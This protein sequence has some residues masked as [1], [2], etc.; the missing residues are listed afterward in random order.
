MRHHGCCLC[1]VGEQHLLYGALLLAGDLQNLSTGTSAVCM[2]LQRPRELR[3]EPKLYLALLAVTPSSHL[4]EG[5][6]RCMCTRKPSH[7]NEGLHRCGVSPA[8][9]VR[10]R[11][12]SQKRR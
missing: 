6:F 3:L 11:F 12:W 1:K 7:K 2:L 5:S 4:T 8:D 10:Y 9:G